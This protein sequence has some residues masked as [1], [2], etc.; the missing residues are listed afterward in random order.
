L[1]PD[2]PSIAGSL[3]G[4]GHALHAAGHDAEAESLVQ[5]GLE[6][7]R[8]R[9]GKDHWLVAHAESSLGSCLAAQG[10]Y[11]EAEPFLRNGYRRMQAVEGV[12]TRLRRESL[13]RLV[14]L[15]EAWGKPDEAAAWRAAVR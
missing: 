13:D 4:L 12:P 9:Y 8:Q 3:I 5:A 2:H 10:R 11:A 14:A 15:Y 6:L 7:R 1:P